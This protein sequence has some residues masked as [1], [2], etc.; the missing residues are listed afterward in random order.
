MFTKAALPNLLT[1]LR[2]VLTLVMFAC[3]VAVAWVQEQGAAM[4]QAM[5]FL[6]LRIALA[7]FVI[8]AVTDFF[9]GWLAR[10]WKVESLFGAILDPIADKILVCAAALG[11]IA[12]HVQPPVLVP[13]GIILFREFAV[14]ALREVLAPRGLILKVTALA[15]IKTALQLVALGAL[16]VAWFA[17]AYGLHLTIDQFRLMAYG[18]HGLIWLAAAVT[19]WTGV[20]YGLSAN[21]ALKAT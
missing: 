2:L 4:D 9:D 6:I 3:F 13:I 17:P 14:S 8:A 16:M 15:K 7:S 20:E 1:V 11:L 12:V 19:L 10:R 5:I 18:A 21:R